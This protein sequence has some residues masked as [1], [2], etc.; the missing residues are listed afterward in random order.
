MKKAIFLM[1]SISLLFYSCKKEN[2][3]YIE[4]IEVVSIYEGPSLKTNNPFTRYTK[5]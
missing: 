5:I 3:N 2:E 1:F 4:N